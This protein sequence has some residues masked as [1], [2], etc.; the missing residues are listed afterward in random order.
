[1]NPLARRLNA[2]GFSTLNLPYPSLVKPLDWILDHVDKQV[3][4]FADGQP[5]HLIGHSLGGIIA[6]MLIA[7]NPCWKPGR[8]VMM[9]PPNHG[10]EIID[11][12]SGKPLL[13]PFL[14]PAARSLA[15]NGVPSKLPPLPSGLDAMVI[16]GGRSSIPFFRNLLSESNDGI[17][18][19]EKGRIEG[20]RDF[21]VIDADHT[22][23]Q[24]HP[25]AVKRTVAFLKAGVSGS[26]SS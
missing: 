13:R 11:W 7:R 5:V 20:L 12:L 17:V 6:R 1:M 18:S 2:A 24:I 9:A 25:E 14:S 21:A 16:M 22:F 19:A 23:I 10:S 3:A 15:T 26:A 4:G 8:L